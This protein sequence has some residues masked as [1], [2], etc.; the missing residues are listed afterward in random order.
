MNFGHCPECASCLRRG[1]SRGGIPTTYC[2]EC[3]DDSP[4]L[5]TDGGHEYVSDLTDLREGDRVLWEGRHEPLTVVRTTF[6]SHILAEG[7]EGALYQVL[8]DHRE[9][10]PDYRL[11]RGGAV[12]CFV[13]VERAPSGNRDREFGRPEGQL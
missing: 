10:R 1:S 11:G 7:P 8:P 6:G 2:P 9:N 3:N 13:R 4:Y 12:H 5:A